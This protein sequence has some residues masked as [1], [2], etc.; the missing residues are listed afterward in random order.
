MWPFDT[1][2]INI[3][4]YKKIRRRSESESGGEYGVTLK[5]IKKM[6]GTEG[7][8]ARELHERDTVGPRF[9][10]VTVKLDFKRQ[11]LQHRLSD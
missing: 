1:F 8:A 9:T 6:S 3:P 4:L 7:I 2:I 10:A 5:K 11:M